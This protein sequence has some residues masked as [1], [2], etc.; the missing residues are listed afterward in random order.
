MECAVDRGPAGYVCQHG[1]TAGFRHETL[2]GLEE[3]P[4]GG[5]GIDDVRTE[6]DVE[7]AARRDGRWREGVCAP[8]HVRHSRRVG[9]T[10]H[11]DAVELDVASEAFH[12]RVVTVCEHELGARSTGEKSGDADAGAELHDPRGRE[13]FLAGG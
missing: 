7:T 2:G 1:H 13:E 6:N 12:H 11:F 10:S 4:R 9:M 3:R 5:G 8:R